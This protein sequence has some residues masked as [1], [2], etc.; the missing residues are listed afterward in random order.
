MA[1]FEE[2]VQKQVAESVND[3]GVLAQRVFRMSR[4]AEVLNVEQ[5]EN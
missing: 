1:Q 5:S 2:Y 3:V 4:T